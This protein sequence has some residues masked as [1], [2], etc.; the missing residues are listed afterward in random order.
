LIA[1]LENPTMTI[2]NFIAAA[3]VAAFGVAACSAAVASEVGWRSMT[4]PAAAAGAQIPLALWYPA[5]AGAV[6]R[7]VAMGPFGVHAAPG[8]PAAASVRGLIV[9]SHGTGGTELGHGRLAEALAARGYLVAALRHPG[10]NW[11]D[12]SLRT[13]RGEQY[14]DERPR[15]VTRVIDTLLADAAWSP[16]IARDARGPR[17]GAVGH[18]AGGYT[19]IALAGGQPAPQRIATHCREHGADDPIFCGLPHGASAAEPKPATGAPLIDP[20]VRAVAALSPVGVVFDPE[21]L[22]RVTT[23]VAIW[24]ADLDRFVVPRFHA[25]WLAQQLPSTT[26][27]R[28]PNAWHYAFMNAPTMPIPSPDGDLA[29]DPPGFDRNRFLEQLGGELS[30]YFDAN[31]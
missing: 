25:E 22:R 19:V 5:E 23:P 3:T 1:F 16:R 30:D 12:Q 10:D 27:H 17:V 8:A 29:A 26:L 24:A 9:L 7:D 31:L 20:R 13:Q 18:S 11:Q 14:F 15:Q 28:V 4:V 6:V 21:S 2:R